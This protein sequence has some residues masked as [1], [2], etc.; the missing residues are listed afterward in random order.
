MSNETTAT[1]GAVDQSADVAAGRD[2]LASIRAELPAGAVAALVAGLVLVSSSGTP[3]P[4]IS[5][6]A[7]FLFF[8]I[9]QDVRSMRIPNWLTLPSLALAIGLGGVS[10]GL[11]GIGTA[12][13]GAA[14]AL[15]ILFLPFAFRI[16]GGG[17][18]KAAMVLGALWGTEALLPTL[19]WMVIAGGVLAIAMIVASG[20]LFDLLGRWA[21]SAKYSFLLRRLVYF[22]PAE[23]SVAAGG[24]PFAVAM[25]IGAAAHQIWGTPWA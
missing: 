10:A 14:A 13:G 5:W 3:L 7:A 17:D 22:P 25:G 1:I 9:H 18:V 6:A 15:G 4:A 21:R 2:I 8:A 19:W 20:G 11:A 16:M 24:L 23:R 12:L